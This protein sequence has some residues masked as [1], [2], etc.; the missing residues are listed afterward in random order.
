MALVA[1][2]DSVDGGVDSFKLEDGIG[3]YNVTA[4]NGSYESAPPAHNAANS[5][6]GMAMALQVVVGIAMISFFV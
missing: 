1:P 5:G 2:L 6:K 4:G 3:L